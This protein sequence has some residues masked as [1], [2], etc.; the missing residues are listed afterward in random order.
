MSKK[1]I[2]GPS[3]ALTVTL[4]KQQPQAQMQIG[5]KFKNFCVHQKAN[6]HTIIFS[7]EN[8]QKV[9]SRPKLLA[10]EK[11][12]WLIGVLNEGCPL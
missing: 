7:P 10:F 9:H 11:K 2:L 12:L 1:S 4:L 5:R 6:D 8:A 3:Y